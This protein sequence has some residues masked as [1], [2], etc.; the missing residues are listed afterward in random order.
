MQSSSIFPSY[1]EGHSCVGSTH[2][3]YRIPIHLDDTNYEYN[4]D[5]SSQ[6]ESRI[7]IPVN[8]RIFSEIDYSEESQQ[9]K[10]HNEADILKLLETAKL[11]ANDGETAFYIKNLEDRVTIGRF[12][13]NPD[14]KERIKSEVR[15]KLW[16]FFRN[17]EGM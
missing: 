15:E 10:D 3:Y 11:K 13:E 1:D 9:R 14:D 8:F 4:Y 12:F 16:I 2:D 7:K 6:K 5:Y 17:I